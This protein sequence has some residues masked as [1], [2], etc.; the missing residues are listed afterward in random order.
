MPKI[1]VVDDEGA[2]RQLVCD[3]LQLKGYQTLQAVDGQHALQVI[4]KENPD[5]VLLDIL[6]P[7]MNGLEAL[8]Q[9]KKEFPNTVV[10]MITALHQEETAKEA[11]ELGAYDYMIKPVNFQLLEEQ[12]IKRLF[13]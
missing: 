12:I 11:I 1:L 2:V 8:R 4:R 7:Q 9:I 3:F 6:M 13:S 10:V 5:L